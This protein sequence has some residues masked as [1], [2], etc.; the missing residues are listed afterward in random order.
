MSLIQV[1]WAC[2]WPLILPYCDGSAPAG[3]PSPA[4]DYLETSLD[5]SEY[6]IENKAATFMMRV[7]MRVQRGGSKA[8]VHYR[9]PPTK[10]AA[11][12]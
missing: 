8:Y 5:L 2:D 4:E 1:E 3:F 10:N 7:S 11:V 9:T 6:L 12:G